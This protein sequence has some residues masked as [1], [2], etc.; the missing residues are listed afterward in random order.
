MS[1][2]LE[3]HGRDAADV[4]GRVRGLC[5]GAAQEGVA[6]YS[7]HLATDERIVADDLLLARRD[8]EPVGTATAYSMQMWVRGHRFSCQ[9]VAYVGT[10]KTQR[11][12]GGVASALMRETLAK[13]RE[14]GQVL[15]A[16]MPF[17]ASF[18]EHFG[19][20]VVERRTSWTI[21]LSVL[22]TGPVDGF[23]FITGVE[24][25]R[26]SCRQRMVEVGQCDFERT[27]GSWAV[28]LLNE[29]EGF[30]VADQARG[31]A[32]RS[33]WHWSQ[34]K[35]NDKDVLHV[36]DQAFDS[37]ESLRRGLA[38]FAT[39]KD[40]FWA[41]TLT[42]PSDFPLFRLLKEVQVP[43]R[44]VNHETAEARTLTRMQV[45][46][47]D[48]VRLIGGIRLPDVPRG[49]AVVAITETEGSVSTLRIDGEG[50]RATAKPTGEAP[51]VECADRTWA[52]IVLGDLPATRAATMG[53]IRV[54]SPDALPVLDAFSAGPA[55]FSNEY[56]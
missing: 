14:R 17:R 19:Y 47:L 39:L 34:V 9:G 48:P 16:L 29:R 32:M 20:G 36:H 3:W 15:S 31:E 1:L 37:M 28:H 6:E 55:P 49:R 12:S 41:V 35:K 56:F 4:V 33:W 8:G 11:R 38:F 2:S 23:R 26:R 27:A 10:I 13:A 46:V 51:D 24:E 50:G 45:R 22:P 5:Y 7:K 42:L 25:G 53:L 44:P 18:Y 21:P 40:Q 52:A 30:V 43:H 54:N